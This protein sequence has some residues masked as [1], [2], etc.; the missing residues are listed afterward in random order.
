MAPRLVPELEVTDLDA[1][2]AFYVGTCGFAIRYRRPEEAFAYLA[3]GGAELMLE[4]ADGPGRRLSDAT[5][6][7]PF[8]RGV[9]LQ[10]E[11]DAVDPLLDRVLAAGTPLVL[12]LEERWYRGAGVELG[13][14]QF[15]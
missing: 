15:V 7:R 2:L 14:R 8:G 11:V 1:S 5:L 13:S 6:E 12:G 4:A 3:L 9:N 10:I